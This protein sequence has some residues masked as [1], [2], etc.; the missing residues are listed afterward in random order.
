VLRRCVGTAAQLA[1]VRRRAAMWSSIAG[2]GVVAV[3]DVVRLDDD[4]IVVSDLALGGGLDAVV[5]RYEALSPGQVV[6]VVVG[7]ADTLAKAHERELVHGR[8]SPGNIVFGADGRPLLTDYLWGGVG[9][10]STDVTNLSALAGDVMSEPMPPTL[11]VAL[12]SAVD[13]RTLADAVRSALQAEPLTS[14]AAAPTVEQ[15]SD[16]RTVVRRGAVALVAVLV[17]AA[18]IAGIAWGRHDNAAGSEL[19]SPAIPSAS[20]T[21]ERAESW[22]RVVQDLEQRRAHALLANS[23]AELSAVEVPGSALWR[24][25]E[26]TIRRLVAH[27][28]HLRGLTAH[29]RSAQVMSLT[30][31]RVVVRVVDALSSYDVLDRHGHV[32]AHES[33]RAPHDVVLGLE[34]ADQRW[35]LRRAISRRSP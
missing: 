9:R 29:V 20:R 15:D 5:A 17:L 12:Q 23:V 32:V 13:A 30:T 6:T 27:R 2:A 3:R 1:E 18:A 21:P 24:R 4:L 33:A 31:S 10:A 7:V 14:P 19:P 34:R 16:E 22:L 28:E 26:R 25:D 35:L 11:L 8:V